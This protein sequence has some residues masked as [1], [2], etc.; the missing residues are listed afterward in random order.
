MPNRD[1]EQPQDFEQLGLFDIR[2]DPKSPWGVPRAVRE[3]LEAVSDQLALAQ[4]LKAET[5]RAI[6]HKIC[7]NCK[8]KKPVEEFP[9]YAGG[10]YRRPLCYPCFNLHRKTLKGNSNTERHDRHLRRAYGI[11]I[12][13]YNVILAA[14]GGVC[15]VCKQPPVTVARRV[16]MRGGGNLVRFSVD[17]DH[18]TGAVRGL[19]CPL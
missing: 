9:L 10:R 13:E 16:G 17:H 15:A 6:G 8:Q 7:R 14:Q 18:V 19:L 3:Q 2:R 5:T 12:E 1:P 4:E 11:S